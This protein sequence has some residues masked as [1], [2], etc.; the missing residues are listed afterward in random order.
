MSTNRI[1]LVQNIQLYLKWNK[2][3][4]FKCVTQ[5]YIYYI[6]LV[7]IVSALIPSS[8]HMTINLPDIR[9]FWNGLMIPFKVE[10]NSH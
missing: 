5:Q 2:N 9:I 1:I 10:T 6:M 3:I 4:N 7:A 8:S